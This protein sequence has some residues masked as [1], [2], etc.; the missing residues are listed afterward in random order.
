YEVSEFESYELLT[1]GERTII[2]SEASLENSKYEW[3][4]Y[5]KMR[6]DSELE[7][8]FLRFV[9]SKKERISAKFSEWIVV[10]NDGFSEFKMYA[11]VDGEVRGFEPDFILFGKEKD[12]DIMGVECFLEVKGG[13]LAGSELVGGIDKWKEELLE[14]L[15][16]E[17]FEIQDK[18]DFEK[19][20]ISIIGLPFFT[21]SNDVKFN[22]KFGEIFG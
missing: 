8:E 2:A 17:I 3:L 13:H 11:E 18:K 14:K 19:S 20:K 9:E 7:R 16:G 10:R 5:D 6:L 15:N 12:G 21:N 1:K 22:E 4:Y